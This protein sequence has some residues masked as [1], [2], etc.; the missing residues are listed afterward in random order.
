MT[1]TLL[2]ALMLNGQEVVAYTYAAEAT[3][4]QT[5]SRLEEKHESKT[6][7]KQKVSLE[8]TTSFVALNLQ[9]AVEPLP[10]PS[11]ANPIDLLLPAY[12][13]IPPSVGFLAQIFPITI[14]PNA[15]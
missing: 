4:Q 2:W 1:F 14:Q 9:Q 3:P 11:F 6:V 5:D 7:V 13:T 15:P 10:Q 8:A 12:T